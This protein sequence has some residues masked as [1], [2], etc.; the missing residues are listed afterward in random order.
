MA[1]VKYYAKEN[2][3]VGTHSFFAVP[4]PN[5]TLTFEE[6]CQEACENTTIEASIL[7]AAVTEYM[8]VVK[9]NVLKGFRV[10]LGDQFITVY[11]NLQL[12]VKD[13]K[14]KQGNDVIATAK[15]LIASNGKS[16]L[17]A[18]VSNRFSQ[19]FAAN[20]SWQKVDAKTGAPVEE[21]DITDDSENPGG[22]T[23]EPSGD[24][25]TPGGDTPGGDT[26]GGDSNDNPDGDG[27]IN[28]G[29]L[30]D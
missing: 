3:N 18:T 30:D 9:R 27:D 17:G 6:L 7:R 2:N 8:K 12:S 20:V 4:L 10:P 25:D 13:T 15:M 16:R 28:D 29:G 24:G 5:G 21:E 23:P 19:E 1:K 11:P 26:P 22:D 14:D